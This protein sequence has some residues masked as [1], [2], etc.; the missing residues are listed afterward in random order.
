[1]QL[2]AL[3]SLLLAPAVLPYHGFGSILIVCCKKAGVIFEVFS[4]CLWPN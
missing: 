4:G 3:V 2:F 1:M